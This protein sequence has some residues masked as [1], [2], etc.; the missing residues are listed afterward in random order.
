MANEYC[1]FALHLNLRVILDVFLDRKPKI[2][3]LCDFTKYNFVVIGSPIWYGKIAPPVNT[4]IQ[5]AIGIENK[6][7][8][9]FISSTL[10]SPTYEKSLRIALEAKKLR[11]L[12][13]FS[14]K[15]SE[16]ADSVVQEIR[17][18]VSRN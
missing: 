1:N 10:N 9:G 6:K 4:L 13:V 2:N 8:I 11:G 17:E 18:L 14:L 3:A 7:V 5:N 12:K 15:D 16:I